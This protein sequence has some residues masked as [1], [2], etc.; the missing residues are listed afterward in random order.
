MSIVPFCY[1]DNYIVAA[2]RFCN[3]AR[4]NYSIAIIECDTAKYILNITNK[5]KA[6]TFLFLAT[7]CRKGTL[8]NI[9]TEETNEQYK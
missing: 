7:I 1:C 8:V 3:Y 4:Q 9:S 6:D 2:K 5:K